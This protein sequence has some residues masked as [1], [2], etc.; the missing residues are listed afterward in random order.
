MGQRGGVHRV[1]LGLVQIGLDHPLLEVVEHH[2]LAGSTKVA[3]GLLVQAGPGLLAGLPHH[4]AKAAPG[5]AQ[6]HHEQARPAV[7]RGAQNTGGRALAVIHLCLLARGELQAVELLG[8][9]LAQPTGK[10]LDTVVGAGESVLI[11]Q[12]LVDGH[13]VALEP[14][15]RFD[16]RAVRLT[17]R[18]RW[19]RYSRWPGWRNLKLRAGGH[20]GRIC[21]LGGKAQLIRA[22]RLAIDPGCTL[23][24]ALAPAR[25]QERRY[26]RL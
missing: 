2:V 21:L 6:R 19:L 16:E 3:P 15:L 10:A 23:N 7:A 18:D 5:V 14:Q 13:E 22:D 20:P 8:S 26:R 4:A 1:E 17:G 25:S 24:L 12:V 9:T 11:D